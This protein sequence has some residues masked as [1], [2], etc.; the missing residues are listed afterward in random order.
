MN[1]RIA[2][3]ALVLM[4]LAAACSDSGGG[5]SA[6]DPTTDP[7]G[8]TPTTIEAGKVAV[9]AGV[10]WTRSTL[11]PPGDA[12]TAVP[13]FEQV[14]ATAGVPP[15][16]A[17]FPFRQ[18]DYI[19]QLFVVGDVQ[20]ASGSC[21]C[22]EGGNSTGVF[23]GLRTPIYLFRSVDAGATWA[24]VDLSGVLG[25]VN[26]Q[27]NNI[28]EYDGAIILTASTTDAAAASP[29]VI[30]VL[31]STDGISWERL[32]TIA[33]DAATPAPVHAFD[34]YQLGSSLVIY[35]GDL[36]CDFTGF[37]SIQSIGPAYQTRLWTS[38]DGGTSWVAQAPADTGL[39]SGRL[40]LPDGAACAG[41]GLSDILD[42]YAS[43]PRLITMANDRLLV[44]SNDGE[45][46]V[47]TAD[48]TS[49]SSTTL[50]GVLALPSESVTDPQ[51]TSYASAIVATDEGFVAM[52]LEDFRNFDDTA[53]GSNVGYSVITWTSADGATWQRQPLGR[54]I[55]ASDD[56]NASYQFFVA[57][58]QLALRV[59]NRVD[60]I[61]LGVF[62]SVAGEAED[63]DTCVAAPDANC[64][65]ATELSTFAPGADLS[66]IDLSYA[67]LEGRDLTDVS[68]E[69]A[70]LESTNLTD[71]TINRTNFNGATLSFVQL[72]GDLTTSSFAGA[73]LTN[74]EFDASF[75]DIELAGATFD[76]PRISISASGLPVGVSMVGRDL[77]RYSLTDGSLAGVDFSG[78]NL[79]GASFSYTDLTGAIFTGAILDDI[80]FFEVT[81]PDGQPI[82]EESFGS[83]RCRL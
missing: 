82:T 67:S 27:I 65:F 5:G 79:T 25:D 39:D 57:E 52:N 14:T 37:S 62:E 61:E 69:G 53:T 73:T 75:F 8:D 47:S 44:W 56:Y 19:S 35:G 21:G 12:S 80:F 11:A 38:T 2:R 16:P 30:N 4:M 29:T 1:A 48:G 55:L 78:A 63:W 34:L 70:H 17:G 72:L 46:I 51:V 18:S 83:A 9:P 50:D 24:Q 33:S 6:T 71:T 42:T 41:L 54:P 81:C 59:F 49:W 45:H 36:A 26:G 15:A 58:G 31:R 77:T 10:N 66:G 20:L 32:S 13:S 22:W 40:P 74:V 3:L 60:V 43:A 23:G 64:S 7:T 76:S 68:F 28:V